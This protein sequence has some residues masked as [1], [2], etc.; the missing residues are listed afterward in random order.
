MPIVARCKSNYRSGHA[1]FRAV[2]AKKSSSGCR[3]LLLRSLSC[4]SNASPDSAGLPEHAGDSVTDTLNDSENVRPITDLNAWINDLDPEAQ[5][6]LGV[7]ADLLSGFTNRDPRGE[8]ANRFTQRRLDVESHSGLGIENRDLAGVEKLTYAL[9]LGELIERHGAEV[10]PCKHTNPPAWAQTEV[11]GVTYRHPSELRAAF[12]AGTVTSVDIVIELDLRP[13][14][15]DAGVAAYARREHRPAAVEVLEQLGERAAKL[16]PYRGHIVRASLAG[17]GGLVLEVIDLPTSLTRE[18]VVVD[19][20]VW[21]EIDL[22]IASVTHQ[23]DTLN[24]HGLGSRRGVLLAGPPGTGKSAVSAV[25]ARE[26]VGTFTVIYVEA[27][28]GASLLTAV[29]EEAERLGGPVLV[30]LEDVDLWCRDRAAGSSGLSELLQAMDI[31]PD[32]PILA[33]ASTNNATTL[34]AAA[35]RTGR[36]DSIVEVGYPDR[37]AAA[38]ILGALC[39]G[40]PGEVDTAAVAAR[41]PGNTSGSDLREIVR[42][43]VLSGSGS[44]SSAALLAEVGSGRY[45]ATVPGDGQYL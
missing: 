44:V 19:E 1:Y 26:L 29:V 15:G 8:D 10:G 9:A 45:K 28:A 41:L 25:I 23:R 39:A 27:Q 43:A 36:F 20:T 13:G 24:A 34:D 14:Y 18:T 22:G 31:Q 5:R 42:R 7:L 40:I 12:P 17:L 37:N 11:G 32:A 33:L 21:R 4:L 6:I 2:H 16:T 30:V 3:C 38:Q 35:I